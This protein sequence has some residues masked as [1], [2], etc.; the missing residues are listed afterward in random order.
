MPIAL[1]MLVRSLVSQCLLNCEQPHCCCLC[2]FRSVVPQLLT[3][4]EQI[5]GFLADCEVTSASVPDSPAR[6][7]LLMFVKSFGLRMC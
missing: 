4:Q 6:C 5:S 7:I 3:G 1:V 2:L